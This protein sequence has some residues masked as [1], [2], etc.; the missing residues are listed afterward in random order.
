MP[1]YKTRTVVRDC[2][3]WTGDNEDELAAKFGLDILFTLPENGHQLK[4]SIWVAANE[5][6]L[7]IE[8]GEWIIKDSHGIYPCKDDVFHE[9]YERL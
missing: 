3:Q 7:N 6:W 8:V 9:K 5:E 4:A 2:E 1:F